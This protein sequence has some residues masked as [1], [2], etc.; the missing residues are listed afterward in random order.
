MKTVYLL[1]VLLIAV[2]CAGW[3][4][5]AR[6]GVEPRIPEAGEQPIL[7]DEYASVSTDLFG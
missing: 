1:R 3:S 6:A 5:S 7:P 4:V 2:A